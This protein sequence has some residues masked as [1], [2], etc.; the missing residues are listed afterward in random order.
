MA[1]SI[2]SQISAHRD[3]RF[4]RNCYTQ[5]T[6]YKQARTLTRALVAAA[7]ALAASNICSSKLRLSS[8][9][10]VEHFL[11]GKGTCLTLWLKEED[12]DLIFVYLKCPAMYSN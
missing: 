3:G 4:R 10:L 12:H 8:T 2:Y 11:P 7:M 1:S 9:S 6:I 5:F